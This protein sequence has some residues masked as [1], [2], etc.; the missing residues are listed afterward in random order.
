[1]I[2]DVTF[3][4]SF[5]NK[6]LELF[7]HFGFDS[8]SLVVPRCPVVIMANTEGQL[9]PYQPQA[10]VLGQPPAQAMGQPPVAVAYNPGQAPAYNP[11]PGQPGFPPVAY[12]QGAPAAVAYNPGGMNQQV[13]VVVSGGVLGRLNMALIIAQIL[14]GR[15]CCTCSEV[16]GL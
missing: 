3:D 5:K 2:A 6:Q 13:N 4:P 11:V 10:Q 7:C 9:P 14:V 12:T 1:M 15:S 8:S 16:K